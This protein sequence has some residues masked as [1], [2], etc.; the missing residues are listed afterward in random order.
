MKVEKTLTTFVLVNSDMQIIPEVLEFTVT[1]EGKGL[2]PNTVKSYLDDLKVFYL[3]LEREELRFYE[4]RPSFIPSF[5]EYVDNRN[6]SGRVSPA[7]LNRYLATLSS[8]YRHYEVIGGFIEESPLK[9]V[10]SPMSNTNRG[11]LRHV[12]KNWDKG[13]HHYFTR[14]LK[15]KTDQKRIYPNIAKKFY[16]TI[17]QLW[18]DD[19]SLRVRNKLIFQLLYKTGFRVSELLHLRINDVDYPDP[20][21]KTGNIYLIERASESL[22]RQLKTGERTVPVSRELLQKIDEY[23]LY[24]CPQKNNIDYIFVS[25]AKSNFGDPISRKSV[26]KMFAVIE[27]ESHVEHFHLT[28]HAL[29]H[30]HASDLA[31]LGVD[32]NVIKERLGHGGINTTAKYAKPSIKTLIMAH[33]RYL[34]IKGGMNFDE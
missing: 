1:L 16:N 2:S 19:E 7:T 23:V 10:K 8:F 21:E 6:A 27:K 9:K 14:K 22:D 24:H 5:I 13:L 15:K 30:T 18:K 4:V 12:T 29:R 31:D 17:D 20:S 34:D 33:E 3:W 11:Y 32:I 28:P 26:E 25:H